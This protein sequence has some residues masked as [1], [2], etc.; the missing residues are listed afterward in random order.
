MKHYK[1]FLKNVDKFD[2]MFDAPQ[3]KGKIKIVSGQEIEIEEF[4]IKVSIMIIENT[5]RGKE[6]LKKAQA[7]GIGSTIRKAEQSAM[8]E[9]ASRLGY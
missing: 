2:V 1:N 5:E 7:I 9:C 3:T 6:V 4:H 8:D